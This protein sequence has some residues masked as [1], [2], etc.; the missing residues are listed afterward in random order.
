MNEAVWQKKRFDSYS[1]L[2]WFETTQTKI[3]ILL[4]TFRHNAYEV[5][6]IELK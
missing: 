1:K 3:A 2:Y 5:I 4:Q 6:E